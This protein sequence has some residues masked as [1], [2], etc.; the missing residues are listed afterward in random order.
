MSDLLA[1]AAAW[2]SDVLAEHVSQSVVYWRGATAIS[3]SAT[4]GR[5]DYTLERSDGT[6]ETG[7]SVD[8]LVDRAALAVDGQL[9]TPARGDRIEWTDDDQR[10]TYQVL[11]LPSAQAYQ[12]DPRHKRLRIHTKLEIVQAL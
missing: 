9:I 5:T 10:R 7:V 12:A 6:V 4:V 1:T 11:V 2:L 3:L 8:F